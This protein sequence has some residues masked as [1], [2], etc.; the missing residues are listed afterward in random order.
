MKKLFTC[1]GVVFAIIIVI[2]IILFAV[3]IPKGIEFNREAIVYLNSEVPKIVEHWNSQELLDAATPEMKS[4]MNDPDEV[5]R[6]FVMFRQ[7]GALKHL[8]EPS[9][10]I[11]MGARTP[12]GSATI[13]NYTIPGEFVK[14]HGVILVQLRRVGDSWKIDGF[15][16]NS[17]VFLPPKL[18]DA[19]H[20]EQAK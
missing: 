9:G 19:R 11:F 12:T 17:D 2:I 18:E 8:D 20:N 3:F 16:I 10:G 15:R 6:L 5:E 7:L 4:M 14:G 13:G 1:L